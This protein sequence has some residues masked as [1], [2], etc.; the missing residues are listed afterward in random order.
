MMNDDDANSDCVFFP[1]GSTLF[2]KINFF[3]FILFF[4][5]III[6][7]KKNNRIT[8]RYVDTGENKGL[9]GKVTREKKKKES[10]IVNIR[11]HGFPLDFLTNVF[12]LFFNRDKE[13]NVSLE[14]FFF[15]FK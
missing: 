15:F 8:K 11:Q 12:L 6:Q 9:V 7:E 1:P 2:F 4:R 14:K 5:P 3:I 13:G 10:R